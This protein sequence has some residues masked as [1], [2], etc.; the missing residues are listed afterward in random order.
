[1]I[2]FLWVGYFRHDSAAVFLLVALN[3]W[4][5]MR[6]VLDGIQCTF[7][8][9]VP[10][11]LWVGVGGDLTAPWRLLT[12]S[13]F[14][15]HSVSLPKHREL[16]CCVCLHRQQSFKAASSV[17]SSLISDWFWIVHIGNNFVF[18]INSTFQI[19]HILLCVG[20]C[21]YVMC[22]SVKICFERN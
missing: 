10:L 4:A 8:A 5:F 17:K 15:N 12:H 9:G 14:L 22:A 6:C 1:M 2:S 19:V 3:E 16:P 18:L 21:I 11:W 7:C 20:V 13:D